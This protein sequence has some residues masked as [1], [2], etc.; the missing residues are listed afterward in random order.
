LITG[1][2]TPLQSFL[3]LAEQHVAAPQNGAHVTQSANSTNPTAITPEEYFDPDFELQARDIGRPVE[4]TS[5]IQRFKA[6]LWLCED[7]PLSLV[8]QVTP[9]IDLMAISNAHFAKLRDFITLKLPPGFP[10]KIEIPLFHVLNARITFGNLCGCDEAVSTLSIADDPATPSDEDQGASG[11][12]D[13]CRQ[14][15]KCEVDP[16]VFEVPRG[17]TVVGTGRSEPMRDEDDDLLQFAI[18][19]SLLDTGTE[20]EQVTIWEAL[21]NSRPG[22]SPPIPYDEESQLERAL[23]ES[24]L[25][26]GGG[27]VGLNPASDPLDPS[28][29]LQQTAYPSFSEQLRQAMEESSK[30]QEDLERRWREEE[31]ELERILQLSLTEK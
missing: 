29:Q 10:V 21:T 16:S 12:A 23:Q 17:Y 20:T 7:H 5:K 27:G 3:S 14:V 22:S 19:Q 30:E 1:T 28:S 31:E 18:Q 2:K 11:T 13:S 15:G 9:I 25:T 24:M 26:H 8:E 6:N 4:L